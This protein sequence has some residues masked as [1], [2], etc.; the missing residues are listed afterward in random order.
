MVREKQIKRKENLLNDAS[1]KHPRWSVTPWH[2]GT[3]LMPPLGPASMPASKSVPRLSVPA[4][5]ARAAGA[6]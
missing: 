3:Q 1:S 2:N 6:G 5:T 4:H